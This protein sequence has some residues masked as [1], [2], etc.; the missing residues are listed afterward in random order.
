MNG[1][2]GWD[3]IVPLLKGWDRPGY[4]D[5]EAA[6][7]EVPNPLRDDEHGWRRERSEEDMPNPAQGGILHFGQ[8]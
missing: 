3:F 5:L 8:G 4:E 6:L 7:L 1:L 2:Q